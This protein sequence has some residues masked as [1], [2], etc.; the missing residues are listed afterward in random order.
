MLVANFD[1]L[2]RRHLLPRSLKSKTLATMVKRLKTLWGAK[3][4][5]D[6]HNSCDFGQTIIDFKDWACCCHCTTV[7]H[8]IEYNGDGTFHFIS[9]LYLSRGWFCS[10]FFWN[11][12]MNKYDS[13]ATKFCTLCHKSTKTTIGLCCLRT[14]QSVKQFAIIRLYN[15]SQFTQKRQNRQIQPHP[16]DLQLPEV[17]VDVH[18]WRGF[19]QLMMGLPRAPKSRP[20]RPVVRLQPPKL[21]LKIKELM[22]GWVWNLQILFFKLNWYWSNSTKAYHQSHLCQNNSKM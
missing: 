14:R 10:M 3:R 13:V 12:I 11:Q 1:P 15:L 20:A 22:K 2:L 9:L 16:K 7:Y 6:E 21:K 8:N 17:K 19:E 4:L 5:K 18:C